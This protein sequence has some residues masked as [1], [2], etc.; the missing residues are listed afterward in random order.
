LRKHLHKFTNCPTTT[1]DKGEAV[2]HQKMNQREKRRLNRERIDRT[3]SY[4]FKGG[5][6][7]KKKTRRGKKK[8]PSW[9]LQRKKEQE[10][11]MKEYASQRKERWEQYQEF[12]RKI[13]E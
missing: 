5:I 9:V 8:K 6:Q 4:S 11:T 1:E 12:R 7:G 10:K 3:K 2:T 13:T